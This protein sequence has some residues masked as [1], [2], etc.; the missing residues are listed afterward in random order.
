MRRLR[1]PEALRLLGV[2]V[3]VVVTFLLWDT[4]LTYPVQLFVVFVHECSHALAGLL[5]GGEVKE[6]RINADLSGHA[7]IVGGWSFVFIQAGY[8]GS[9]AAGAGLVVAA[10]RPRSARTTLRVMA[11]LTAAFG[12]AFTASFF[13]TTFLFALLVAGAFAW[14]SRDAPDEVVRWGLIYIATVTAMYALIDIREDLLHWEH[15]GE[16]DA[17]I[18][19]QRTGIPALVWA[20]AWAAVS[21]ALLAAALRRVF[22]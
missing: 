9:A 11:V 14:A 22:R 10:A 3:M 19:A 7:I 5:T 17:V 21:V 8:L 18:L 13:S 16:N 20:I 15:R 6:I 1:R 4:W 2:G 12:V